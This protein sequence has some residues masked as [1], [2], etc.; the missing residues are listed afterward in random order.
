MRGGKIGYDVAGDTPVGLFGCCQKDCGNALSLMGSG[1]KLKYK[2]K[3][4][5]YRHAINLKLT[6]VMYEF[7]NSKDFNILLIAHLFLPDQC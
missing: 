1:S 3:Q 4:V 6:C 2:N 7:F 5:A